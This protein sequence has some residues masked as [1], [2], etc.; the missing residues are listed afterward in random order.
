MTH[1]LDFEAL[2]G[3]LHQCTA[4]WPDHRPEGPNTRYAIQDAAWGTFSIFFTQSP[5]FL[6][7]QRRRHHTP[8]APSRLYPRHYR[9]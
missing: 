9:E 3:L 8:R 7:Y 6:E 4:H 5:S 1:P 2:E